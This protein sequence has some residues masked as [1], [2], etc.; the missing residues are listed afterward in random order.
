MITAGGN[1]N[2][3]SGQIQSCPKPIEKGPVSG[4]RKRGAIQ[5]VKGS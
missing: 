3:S 4:G 2:L 5:S 1:L